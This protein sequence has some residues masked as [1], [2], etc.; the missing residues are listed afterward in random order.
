MKLT[1]R[2]YA[3]ALFAAT[4]GADSKAADQAVVRL[5]TLLRRSRALKLYPRIIAAFERLSR[6]QSGKPHVKV[7]TARPHGAKQLAALLEKAIGPASLETS[8][9]P[10]LQGGAV[11]TVGDTRIDGSVAAALRRLR[12][13]LASSSLA[14]THS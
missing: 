5:H 2:Q 13:Q 6:A 1:P 11:L 14:V 8:V 4:R 9:K 7:E 10:E 3:E 12:H